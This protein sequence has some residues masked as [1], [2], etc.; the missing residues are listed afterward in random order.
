MK[1]KI[2][3]EGQEREVIIQG[4]NKNLRSEFYDKIK[5]LDKLDK[6][7]G[8]SDADKIDSAT[9]LIDWLEQAGLKHSNLTDEEKAKVDLEA[10]DEISAAAREIL[11]P[12]TVKKKS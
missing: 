5:E 11:Q 3:I 6:E 7:E 10:L 12:S 4:M 9:R 8:K 1:I 2:I